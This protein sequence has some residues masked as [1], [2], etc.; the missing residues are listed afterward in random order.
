MAYLKKV[1]SRANLTMAPTRDVV[2]MLLR[3]SF[4]NVRLLGRGVDTELFHPAKRDTAL[5]ASW[6]AREGSPVAIIVVLSL[7][8]PRFQPV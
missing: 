2:D 4:Q 8:W 5:R 7:I 6:G 1:H 3:E